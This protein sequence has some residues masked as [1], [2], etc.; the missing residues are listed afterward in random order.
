MK[1][2]RTLSIMFIVSIL[3]LIVIGIAMMF[4]VSFTSGL[5]EYK[6]YYYFIIR[7]IAWII[8]GGFFMIIAS[9]INYKR[10]KKMRGLFFVGA[11]ILLI[12]VLLVGK[13]VNGAKRWLNVGPVAIQPSEVAKLAFIIYLS[14]ALDYYREKKYKSLEIL[15]SSIIPLLIFVILIFAE[16][17]F[18]S[19]AIVFLIGFAMIF[20]SK[21]KLEQLMLFFISFLM[22][23]TAGIMHSDY[24]RRRILSYLTGFQQDENGIGYQAKQSLIAIG[25]GRAIGRH[26]GNGLQK[27]YYL[28]ERHTDYVFSTYAEEFGFIGCIFLV[29][30]YFFILLIMIIT[31][32]KTKDYFGKY[33]VFGIMVLFITQVLANMFVVTGVIPSTG[34]TLPLISYGGS[35]TIVMMVALGIIINVINNIN[36]VNEDE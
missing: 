29:G 36:E 17:S 33:L 32:N 6:N 11:L 26:Y 3:I 14:G 2:K 28:P 19:A 35:S 20:V 18:S 22:L 30:I 24:R 31:I 34:I 13:E 12:A 7:Q 4:S 27:Y 10:Y 23:A 1:E 21:V 16:K 8:A 5:H 25:S 9:K 15:I